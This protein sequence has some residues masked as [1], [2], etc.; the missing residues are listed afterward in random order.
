MPGKVPWYGSVRIL[1]NSAPLSA[2][3]N[4]NFEFDGPGIPGTVR[5]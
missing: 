5:V 3:E 1:Q 4:E 2:T